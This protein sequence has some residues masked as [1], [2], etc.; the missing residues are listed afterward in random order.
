MFSRGETKMSTGLVYIL[1]ILDPFLFGFIAGNDL[2]WGV[3]TCVLH[4][5]PPFFLKDRPG[6]RRGQEGKRPNVASPVHEVGIEGVTLGLAL[7]S[8]LSNPSFR[9]A[10][11]EKQASLLCQVMGTVWQRRDPPMLAAWRERS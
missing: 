4:A 2:D 1:I 5:I 3:R 7:L 10:R 11:Q 8:A 9:L 6:G